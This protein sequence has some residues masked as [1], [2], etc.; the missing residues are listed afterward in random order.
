MTGRIARLVLLLAAPLLAA[1]TLPAQGGAAQ[2]VTGVS[3]VTESD[4][5]VFQRVK[6]SG[7]KF[8]HGWVRWHQI[9]PV[10]EPESWNP[11]NPDDPNYDWS[12][13]DTWV[14]NAVAAGL[15]PLL[16]IYYAPDWAQRCTTPPEYAAAGAP[17]NPDP[18]KMADFGRAAAKRYD[19]T[20]PGL[21]RVRYWQPQNEPNLSI[22]FYP[23]FNNNGTPASPALYR[24]LLNRYYTAVKSVNRTNKV[25]AAGLAPNGNKSAVAPMVFARK[26][27]CMKG[28]A[29]PKPTAANCQVKMDIFDMHPYTSGGPTHKGYG[30]DN[31]QLGDLGKLRQLLN[32][33][34]RAGRIKGDGNRTP[35]W[36]TEMSWDSNRPDPG[37]VPM[38][39]LKRW[40]SEAVFRSFKAGVRTFMWYTLRDQDPKDRPWSETAQSGLFFRGNTVEHDRA[41][42]IRQ[43]FRFPFVTFT[44]NKVKRVRRKHRWVKRKVKGITLWGRTPTSTGGWVVIQR[45]Q[46][47]SWKRIGRVRA[48]GNGVFSRWL[49]V[50]GSNRAGVVRAVHRSES[51]VPFSL[52]KVPDRPARP[53]G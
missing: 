29:K 45:K 24:T 46:G 20:T 42:P 10:V 48:N 43:A 14:T 2:M 1:V 23:Q 9:A 31:V 28:R 6:E 27:L 49:K 12:A 35:L 38:G 47:G 3:Y 5:V 30:K 22:F 8:V 41:K 25:L 26:L 50:K 37:G 11:R 32:A 36:V 39:I 18:D 16:Q 44:R 17:C 7:T 15:T 40:T 4:P 13:I 52:K 51:S 53:F 19:G 33:A 21:P 34:D